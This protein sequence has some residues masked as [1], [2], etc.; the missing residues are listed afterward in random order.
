MTLRRSVSIALVAVLF[1]AAAYLYVRSRMLFSQGSATETTHFVIFRGQNALEAGKALQEK[2]L[3]S[4]WAY[5]SAYLWKEGKLHELRAGE[6]DIPPGLTIAEIVLLLT[7]EGGGKRQVRVTFPEGW[8]IE[9]MALR[10]SESGFDGDGFLRVAQDPPADLL[11]KYPIIE[12]NLPEGASLEGFL[13]PDTYLF[14]H[15]SDPQDII[16]RMLGNFERKISDTMIADTAAQGKEF[17]EILTMASIIEGE[18]P[19]LQDR[20]IV[21]GI[22]WKRMEI[23][24]RLESDATLAYA[25]GGARKR[26][27]SAA[28]TALDSPYNTYR[29]KGLPPGPINNPGV[30][31]I[32]AAIYPQKSEYFFF[33]SDT[34]TGKTVFS[35]TFEEHVANKGKY[36]L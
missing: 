6:Y 29:A 4:H 7:E 35:R 3:I 33:L 14:L 32:T 13:F 1:L 36:G 12:E 26:Q 31:A 30:S 27:H 24:M 8:T 5:F 15:D 28:E 23:G 10:L 21:S 22:F 19:E 16:T 18:V 9:D 25:L 34:E 2:G 11:A 20:Y 17:F